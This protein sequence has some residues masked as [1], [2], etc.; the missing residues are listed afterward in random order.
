MKQCVLVSHQEFSLKFVRLAAIPL[1]H[2]SPSERKVAWLLDS[3]GRDWQIMINLCPIML[4]HA[5]LLVKPSYYAQ[6]Y[7]GSLTVLC[8]H[9]RSISCNV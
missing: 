1:Y 2:Y 7:A 6:Y 4:C 5:A 8:I 3:R 9:M